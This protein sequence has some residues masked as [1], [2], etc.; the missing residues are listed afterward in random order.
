M[1]LEALTESAEEAKN[2]EPPLVPDAVEELVDATRCAWEAY[3][4]ASVYGTLCGVMIAMAQL[5][6][7]NYHELLS[8]AEAH[9]NAGRRGGKAHGMTEAEKAEAYH[10][11]EK[12]IQ[13]HMQDMGCKKR[14][15]AMRLLGIPSSTFYDCKRGAQKK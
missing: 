13:Q 15:I 1:L 3:H 5:G 11:W 2:G 12:E 9:R 7:E 6:T 14:K 10:R 8:S 4:E